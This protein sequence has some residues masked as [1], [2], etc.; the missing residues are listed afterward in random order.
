[1]IQS[2]KQR[3]LRALKATSLLALC[4]ALPVGYLVHWQLKLKET[5]TEQ[6]PSLPLSSFVMADSSGALWTDQS[7]L[8]SVTVVAWMP[9]A[10]SAEINAQNELALT[11]VNQ[12]LLSFREIP[13]AEDRNPLR[14]FC[15]GD[16]SSVKTF[17]LGGQHW[18]AFA[19]AKSFASQFPQLNQEL[20][21]DLKPALLIIDP[22]LH[23][24]YGMAF[25]GTDQQ[26]DHFSREL[27]RITFGQYLDTYL[28]KRTFMGPKRQ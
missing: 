14:Q 7:L 15:M 8:G 13:H 23:R 10:K 2:N 26:L 5:V 11:K 21:Q 27:T 6:T 25:D 19:K 18:I 9:E 12:A 22:K 4:L 28:A 17:S 24:A 3:H 1:M 20:N 16:C